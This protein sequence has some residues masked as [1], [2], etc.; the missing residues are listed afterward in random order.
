MAQQEKMH[1]WW[2]LWGEEH[3]ALLTESRLPRQLRYARAY[4]DIVF[5]QPCVPGRSMRRY[6]FTLDVFAIFRWLISTLTWHNAAAVKITETWLPVSAYHSS[7]FREY[8][9][10]LFWFI[11]LRWALCIDECLYWRKFYQKCRGHKYRVSS[12]SE[13]VP[14]LH[15]VVISS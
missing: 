7:S 4:D 3:D 13:I 5:S 12:L 11:T 10:D 1:T 2:C 8:A 15:I 6:Q 9:H 14:R